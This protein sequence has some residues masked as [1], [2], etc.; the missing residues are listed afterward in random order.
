MTEETRLRKGGREGRRLVNRG[1][2]RVGTRFALN[3][4][5]V[6]ARSSTD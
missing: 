2:V 5:E 1:Q 4:D 3:E 6:F